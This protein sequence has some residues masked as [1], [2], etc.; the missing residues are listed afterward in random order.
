MGAPILVPIQSVKQSVTQRNRCFSDN[1]LSRIDAAFD[2]PLTLGVYARGGARAGRIRR[3]GDEGRWDC[4]GS[5]RID[6]VSR[7]AKRKQS[8][9]TTAHNNWEAGFSVIAANRRAATQRSAI[10]LRVC[11]TA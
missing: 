4:S 9:T 11:G 5:T 2:G 8:V 3:N 6:Q 1:T 7:I 10:H